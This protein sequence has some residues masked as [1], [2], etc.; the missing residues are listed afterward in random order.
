MNFKIMLRFHSP[1]QHVNAGSLVLYNKSVNQVLKPWLDQSSI[2]GG[3]QKYHKSVVLLL[4]F[5][6]EIASTMHHVSILDLYHMII[7][8]GSLSMSLFYHW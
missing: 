2:K 5:P 7:M 4:I 8:D 6:C 3:S 1:V